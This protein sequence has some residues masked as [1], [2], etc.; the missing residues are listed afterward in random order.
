M[1][2]IQRRLTP[3]KN[4]ADVGRV[5]RPN[6]AML[7][8]PTQHCCDRVLMKLGKS[9][10]LGEACFLVVVPL[11]KCLTLLSSLSIY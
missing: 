1:L 11:S 5:A 3:A 4:D 10:F 9:P 6:K 7:S 8:E 2:L